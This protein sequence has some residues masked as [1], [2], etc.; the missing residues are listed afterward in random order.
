MK[1]IK[2][3][4]V[5]EKRILYFKCHY[6]G[7]IFACEKGECRKGCLYNAPYYTYPC[8]TCGKNA[9]SNTKFEEGDDQNG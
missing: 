7:C 3:G 1:I 2:K 4:K 9:Y 6:C 8:P 5:P